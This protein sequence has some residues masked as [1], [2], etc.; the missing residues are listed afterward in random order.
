V[1][2]TEEVFDVMLPSGNEATKVM[3]PREEPLDFP[4]LSVAAQLAPVLTPASIAPV[5]RDH[6]DVVFLAERGACGR[7]GPNR[8]PCRR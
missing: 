6:L 1:D 2:E 4:A 7:A 8:R 5:G 3:H